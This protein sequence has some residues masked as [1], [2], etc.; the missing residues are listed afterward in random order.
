MP[1]YLSTKEIKTDFACV[2]LFLTFPIFLIFSAVTSTEIF[3]LGT[4]RNSFSQIINKNLPI[5]LVQ[6]SI[7][8]K[9][10]FVFLFGGTVFETGKENSNVLMFDF[11][12]S[13]WRILKF[14]VSI[15]YARYLI[16]LNEYL[17]LEN[18]RIVEKHKPNKS[19][20]V[21]ICKIV[22][23]NFCHCC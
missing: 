12:I 13:S 22:D 11:S 6:P 14:Q 5:N 1:R 21:K 3:Y 4:T 16:R 20:N 19:R 23:K 8:Y 9:S 18:R 17:F 10:G 2:S 15:S 7:V